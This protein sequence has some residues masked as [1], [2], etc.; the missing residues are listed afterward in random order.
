[1][2]ILKYSKVL[3]TTNEWFYAPDGRSY[4][5][6]FGKITD[7]VEMKDALGFT[8]TTGASWYL[9]M[10]DLIIMGGSINYIIKTENCNP[11]DGETWC[12]DPQYGLKVYNPPCSIYFC[13]N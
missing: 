5:A 4:R 8:P 6:A 12:A 11:C 2:G 1:M 10:G 3:V 7:I 13:K 9:E